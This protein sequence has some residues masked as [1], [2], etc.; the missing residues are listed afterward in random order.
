MGFLAAT[1]MI[2]MSDEDTFACLTALCQTYGMG[3]FFQP[4]FPLLHE[5]FYVHQRLL[6]RH[7]PRLAAHLDAEMIGAEMYATHWY[8]TLF[9]YTLPFR[10]VVRIVDLFL[11]EKFK[12]LFRVAIA[13]LKLHR[14]ELIGQ[15]FEVIVTKIKHFNTLSVDPD[16][17]VS[18]V[19]ESKIS[20]KEIEKFRKQYRATVAPP[21]DNK[22]NSNTT[23]TASN[24]SSDSKK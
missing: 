15:S 12:M 22:L 9:S 17:F 6:E 7:A 16:E 2:Y 18:Q 8:T 14:H 13:L 11:S 1:F 24:A 19:L 3:G 23:N 10:Y 4:G 21:A 20:D 5:C